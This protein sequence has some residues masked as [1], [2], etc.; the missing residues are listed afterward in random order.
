M[1][2]YHFYLAGKISIFLL[3]LL[4]SA[5][6]L[7]SFRAVRPLDDLFGTL[8]ITRN[9]A[10][11]KITGSLLGGYFNS[12]G[13]KNL[14]YIA[15]VDRTAIANDLLEY[16]KNYTGSDKFRNEYQAFREQNKPQTLNIQS[17]EDMRSQM[18]SSYRKSIA[19]MEKAVQNAQPEMKSIFENV[20]QET[21]KQLREAESSQDQTIINYAKSYPQLVEMNRT[22]FEQTIREW[23]NLYPVNAEDYIK[24]RLEQ[25][26]EYT[27]DIDFDATLR[28]K[29]DK[30]VFVNPVYESKS[31]Y[32]KMAF[33]SG[34]NVVAASRIFAQRWITEIN[35][36]TAR[37]KH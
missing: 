35:S 4:F 36:P 8:G 26:L 32:W 27:R 30:Q 37:G 34:R 29:N 12:Y 6:T 15:S 31:K 13:I 25:F 17:P 7:V 21:R 23:E 14:R 5:I 2:K 3:I 11:S 9:E 20:L 24:R 22:A 10:D 28:E 16:T 18:I 1:K 19:E 33:R